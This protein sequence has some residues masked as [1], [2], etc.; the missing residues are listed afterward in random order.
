MA[1]DE[2]DGPGSDDPAP[3]DHTD[4]GALG[5][6]VIDG[7]RGLVR[8][9]SEYPYIETAEREVFRQRFG[10]F[11]ALINAV[12]PQMD[13]AIKADRRPPITNHER[14]ARLYQVERMFR[15]LEAVVDPKKEP[16]K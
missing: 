12:W 16:P 9:E 6:A 3:F 11:V 13:A 14:D 8:L 7:G 10:R 4:L 5:R 15:A 1:P 2:A